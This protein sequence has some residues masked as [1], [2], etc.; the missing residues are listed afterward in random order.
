MIYVLVVDDIRRKAEA[1]Q[2]NLQ[3][4]EFLKEIRREFND[5]LSVL[6]AQV[7]QGATITDIVQ[8]AKQ[9]LT[10]IAEGSMLVTV[11]DLQMEGSYQG[12]RLFITNFESHIALGKIVVIS[13]KVG[14]NDENVQDLVRSYGAMYA[15]SSTK[16]QRQMAVINALS[17]IKKGA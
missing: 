14:Q 16:S 6:V 10:K 1:I 3:D 15:I 17:F 2:L 5:D 11:L 12:A 8:S 9:E 7:K 13:D 4:P